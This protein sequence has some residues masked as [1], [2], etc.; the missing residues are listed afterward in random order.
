VVGLVAG[1]AYKISDLFTALL[2]I[3]ANDAA[4]ALTQAT[5]SYS[6]GMSL[7]NA[8]ARHLQPWAGRS[9]S[10]LTQCQ[11]L[12]CELP[13]RLPPRHHLICLRRPAQRHRGLWPGLRLPP[14]PRLGLGFEEADAV[15]DGGHGLA[16]DLAGPGGAVREDAVKAGLVGQDLLGLLPDRVEGGHD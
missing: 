1:R 10:V 13:P 16:G 4:I 9:E 5:G 2:T 8:E 14:R 15:A 3:S 11:A 12:F 6:Q 7:I